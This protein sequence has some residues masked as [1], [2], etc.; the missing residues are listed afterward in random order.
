[1]GL[2]DLGV[3]PGHTAAY[4][5]QVGLQAGLPACAGG[6]LCHGPPCALP[7]F[8]DSL[9]FGEGGQ[10]ESVSVS[11]LPCVFLAPGSRALGHLH[12]CLVPSFPG[13]LGGRIFGTH[14]L[15][16]VSLPRVAV[17]LLLFLMRQLC[18]DRK[19]LRTYL[20]MLPRESLLPV[21]QW[22]LAALGS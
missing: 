2:E 4:R 7:E 21:P 20:G 12:P 5:W 15:A 3:C 10:E 1:M 17:V 19:L 22:H 6:A 16:V 11:F 9:V 13:A 14:P 18:S 8:K